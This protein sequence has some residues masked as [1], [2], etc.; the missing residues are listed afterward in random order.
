MQDQKEGAKS[1]TVVFQSCFYYLRLGDF[2]SNRNN[3]FAKI[4]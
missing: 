1:K 3:P 4:I 2:C